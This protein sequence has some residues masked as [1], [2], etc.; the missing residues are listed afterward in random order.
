MGNASRKEDRRR[1]K[2]ECFEMADGEESEG[3][4]TKGIQMQKRGQQKVQEGSE[5]NK[6]SLGPMYPLERIRMTEP[7]KT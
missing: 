4:T 6:S 7:Q 1:G 2:L 5:S 3:K